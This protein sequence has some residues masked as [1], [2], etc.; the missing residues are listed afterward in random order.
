MILTD[1]LGPE[2]LRSRIGDLVQTGNPWRHSARETLGLSAYRVGDMATARTYITE[3]VDD[4]ESG[5]GVKQRAQLMLGL[6][7][8]REG[9]PSSEPQEG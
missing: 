2:E 1:T 5:Q 4:E 3:I 6:I 8:S 7:Q 9:P